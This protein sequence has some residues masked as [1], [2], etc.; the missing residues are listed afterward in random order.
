MNSLNEIVVSFENEN[1][2]NSIQNNNIEE[3]YNK[4]KNLM[5]HI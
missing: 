1:K 2:E 5:N 3:K 4:K